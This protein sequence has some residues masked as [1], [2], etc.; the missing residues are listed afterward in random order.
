MNEDSNTTTM[1]VSVPS[2]KRVGG[3]K[4]FIIVDGITEPGFAETDD[5]GRRSEASDRSSSIL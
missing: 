4:K 5:V 1:T 2:N 3:D